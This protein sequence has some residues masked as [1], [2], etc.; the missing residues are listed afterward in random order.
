M[1]NKSNKKRFQEVES[2][3]PYAKI[4]TLES[5]KDIKVAL[6]EFFKESS[7]NDGYWKQLEELFGLMHKNTSFEE[8]LKLIG[9]ETLPLSIKAKFIHFENAYYEYCFNID[10]AQQMAEAYQCEENN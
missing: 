3:K 9:K 1:V 2:S 10:Y 6:I 7:P 5:S 4:L 8:A